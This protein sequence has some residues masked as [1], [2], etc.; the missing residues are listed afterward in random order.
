MERTQ[1]SR[2]GRAVAQAVSRWL[3]TEAAPG[4]MWGLWWTKR[5]WGKFSPSISVPP[6]HH[7]STNLSIIV[8]TR[9][10]HN[11][12]T[13][14]CSAEWT[15]LES[16]PLLYQLKITF[17]GWHCILEHQAIHKDRKISNTTSNTKS[18]HLVYEQ[19]MIVFC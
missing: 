10:W 19:S 2:G 7:H 18:R 3:P 8:I 12:P 9:A 15:Q 11:R 4:S 17:E 13:D 14:G 1:L 5:H 16:T 6:A